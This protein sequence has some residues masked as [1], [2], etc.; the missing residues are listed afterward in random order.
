M[1]YI[2]ILYL[3]Y[4]L[5]FYLPLEAS[6]GWGYYCV[7]CKIMPKSLWRS[8]EYFIETD[9]KPWAMRC[10]ASTGTLFEAHHHKPDSS[11]SPWL[12]S[13]CSYTAFHHCWGLCSSHCGCSLD[14]PERLPGLRGGVGI[15]RCDHIVRYSI[16]RW[17]CWP[18]R[19]AWS[20]E[21]VLVRAMSGWMWM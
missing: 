16:R 2:Y 11:V 8:I 21:L 19:D 20:L 1:E 9:E 18:A 5:V 4:I 10:M 3:C 13:F 12:T 6:E 15:A 7:S 14:F 17:T